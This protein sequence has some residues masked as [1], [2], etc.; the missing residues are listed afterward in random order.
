M[1][2]ILVAACLAL[3]LAPPAQAAGTVDV[4]FKPADQLS[5]IGQGSLDRERNVKALAQ[6][7]QSLAA[8][9][10][11][12]QTLKVEVLDVNLAG[13]LRPTR[14]G[15]EVRVMRGGADWPALDLRWQLLQGGRTLSS[16]DERL[17]DMAYLHVG[18][19]RAPDSPL[20]YEARMIDR[21]FDERFGPAAAR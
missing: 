17:A 10:P 6:H 13:E 4:S 20:P 11:D 8:R 7:F 12:G 3:A 21:W 15:D 19:R 18:R 9:L 16:G 5:D 14:R 1:R 2:H